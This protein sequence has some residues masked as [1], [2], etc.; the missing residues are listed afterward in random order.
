VLEHPARRPLTAVWALALVAALP[1]R[2]RRPTAGR[3][4]VAALGL[5]AAAEVAARLAAPSPF[6]PPRDAARLLARP[7]LAVPGWWTIASAPAD[8]PPPSGEFYQPQRWPAGLALAERL[9]IAPGR[10]EITLRAE[11]LPAPAVAPPRLSWA[12]DRPGAPA[13]LVELASDPRGLGG[14]FEIPPGVAAVNLRL[15]GGA[16]MLLKQVHLRAQPSRSGP[17]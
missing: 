6:E 5:T 2:R 9:P 3:L 13:H 4:A 11:P 10:Y 14:W 17:V 1:W 12:A 15:L 16:P 8:W 7:A